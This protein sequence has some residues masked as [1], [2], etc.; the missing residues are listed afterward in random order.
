MLKNK[1]IVILAILLLV[2]VLC[3]IFMYKYYNKDTGEEIITEETNITNDITKIDTDLVSG[4]PEEITEVDEVISDTEIDYSVKNENI[5][6]KLKIKY[7][8]D[9]HSFDVSGELETK[10]ITVTQVKTVEVIRKVPV[11][12]RPPFFRIGTGAMLFGTKDSTKPTGSLGIL[13]GNKLFLKVGYLG[14]GDKGCAG[15]GFTYI[16]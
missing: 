16:F 1:V 6:G 2:S 8:L 4:S 10:V 7:D 15:V 12:V 3:N 11:V 9:S 14:I 13:F 5:V